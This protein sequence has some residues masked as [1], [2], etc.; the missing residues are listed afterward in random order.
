MTEFVAYKSASFWKDAGIEYLKKD[1]LGDPASESPTT[2]ASSG[3][4]KSSTDEY[5]SVLTSLPVSILAFTALS[6]G[7]FTLFLVVKLR[8]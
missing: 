6:A 5:K 1:V 3:V 7:A 2:A 8:K 4:R